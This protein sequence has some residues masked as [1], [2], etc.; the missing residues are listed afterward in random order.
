M[1]KKLNTIIFSV[2]DDENDN[3]SPYE[4]DDNMTIL[5]EKE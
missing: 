1:N 3:D 2:F 4:I 5:I